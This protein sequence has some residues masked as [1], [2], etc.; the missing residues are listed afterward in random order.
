MPTDLS[1]QIKSRNTCGLYHTPSSFHSVQLHSSSN[2]DTAWRITTKCQRTRWGNHGYIFFGHTNNSCND[3]RTMQCAGIYVY[4]A[5]RQ[6]ALSWLVRSVTDL[7]TTTTLGERCARDNNMLS[8]LRQQWHGL[9]IKCEEHRTTT[10]RNNSSMFS[11]KQEAPTK[12]V[13]ITCA[14]NREVA[15]LR[16]PH[17]AIHLDDTMIYV[18][19]LRE[20]LRYFLHHMYITS[21]CTN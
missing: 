13:Y 8:K 1:N 14:K 9:H 5:D 6:T 12:H 7:L 10:V 20:Y 2:D 15:L 18:H 16:A 19:R 21:W 17:A 11:S 4:N 3:S